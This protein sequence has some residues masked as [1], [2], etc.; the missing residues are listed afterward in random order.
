M[1]FEEVLPALRAG[2]KIRP[3]AWNDNACIFRKDDTLYFEDGNYCHEKFLCRA[4][5]DESIDWE[6]VK[7][8][9]HYADYLE[10]INEGSK[11][12]YWKREYEVGTQPAGAILMP[13][14]KRIE[15]EQD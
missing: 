8:P 13:G 9:K 15:H 2:K 1:K 10:P 11:D 5:F 6:I 7:E 4:I 14:T 3:S 12:I